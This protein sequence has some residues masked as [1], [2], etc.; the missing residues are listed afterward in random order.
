MR[1]PV[2]DYLL[3]CGQASHSFGHVFMPNMSAVRW[4]RRRNDTSFVKTAAA[5]S[6]SVILDIFLQTSSQ[7]S[8]LVQQ[9]RPST[10][11]CQSAHSLNDFEFLGWSHSALVDTAGTLTSQ[12]SVLN[13]ILT[14]ATAHPKD[15]ISMS[16]SPFKPRMSGLGDD[17]ICPS[18][19][20]GYNGLSEVFSIY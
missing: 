19:G 7:Q 8:G 16:I 13:A 4:Q 5:R 2:V 18:K 12:L 6:M 17:N 14:F 9:S 11:L 15:G 20:V 1:R 10:Y 3:P